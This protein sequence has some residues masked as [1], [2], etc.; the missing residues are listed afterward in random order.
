MQE[1]LLPELDGLLATSQETL[2]GLWLF[3]AVDAN[4]AYMDIH[5]GSGGTEAC[6][7]AS[8]LARMYTRWAQSQDYT[9]E[10]SALF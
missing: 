6:D 2:V 9:G 4:S 5:A 3:E 7:W 10:N 8:M 1:Q